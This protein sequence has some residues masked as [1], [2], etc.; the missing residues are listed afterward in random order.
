MLFFFLYFL[1]VMVILAVIFIVFSATGKDSGEKR[2]VSVPVHRSARSHAGADDADL[3]IGDTFEEQEKK[4]RADRMLE[5][6]EVP[7]WDELSDEQK[8]AVSVWS[9][10]GGLLEDLH[11]MDE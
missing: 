3:D 11:L 7:S 6:G 5:N 1:I 2:N 9:E 4:W 8:T 10:K